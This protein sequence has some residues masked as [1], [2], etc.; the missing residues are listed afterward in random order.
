MFHL[1]KHMPKGVPDTYGFNGID[2]SQSPATQ[3]R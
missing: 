2:T 1:G 3:S